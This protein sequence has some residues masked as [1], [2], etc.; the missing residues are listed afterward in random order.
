MLR[1]IIF[2]VLLSVVSAAYASDID[3]LQKF[4]IR[5]DYAGAV[6]FGK[7]AVHNK[8]DNKPALAYYYGEALFYNG[9]H[10][11]AIDIYNTVVTRFPDSDYAQRALL[12]VGDVYYVKQEYER[13]LKAY[14]L[15]AY[16]FKDHRFVPYVYLKQIYCS[17]KLGLWEEKKKY[18]SLLKAD[19]PQSVEASL[20][21]ELEKRGYFYIVQLGAFGSRENAMKLYARLQE[22]RIKSVIIE[23][24]VEGMALYKVIAGKFKDRNNADSM[25]Y[26]LSDKGYP[27]K[28][29]P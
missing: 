23:D 6:E 26:S 25:V 15:F 21:P 28:R 17:E 24:G 4:I 13:A 7:T 27:A 18:I 19:Y 8:S 29:F 2:F 10:S 20:I 14:D 3:I 22:D 5:K 12:R 11:D 9:N 1:K 16:R